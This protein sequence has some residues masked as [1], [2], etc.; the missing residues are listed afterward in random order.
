[1]SAG[2]KITPKLNKYWFTMGEIAWMEGFSVEDAC[3]FSSETMPFVQFCAGW[4]HA[5]MNGVQYSA[6]SNNSVQV[7]V[8]THCSNDGNLLLMGFCD[9]CKSQYPHSA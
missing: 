4:N 7:T 9:Q 2:W 5:R 3:P 1:M 6:L 8:L